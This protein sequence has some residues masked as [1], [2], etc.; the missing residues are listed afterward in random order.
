MCNIVRKYWQ[1]SKEIGKNKTGL[2]RWL[3]LRIERN[4]DINTTVIAAYSPYNSRKKLLS[5]YTQQMRYCN[6]KIINGCAKEKLRVDLL[7]F[8]KSCRG[9]GDIIILILDGNENMQ[10]SK[11]SN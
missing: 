9:K 6:N 7:A 4:N 10:T 2:G 8:I 1:Y 11:L 3:W 5:I